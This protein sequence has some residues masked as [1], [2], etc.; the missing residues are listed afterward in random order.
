MPKGPLGARNQISVGDTGGQVK[1]LNR[2]S[3]LDFYL[4]NY[5][6]GEGRTEH[7]VACRIR[8]TKQFFFPFSSGAEGS[9]KKVAGW[10]QDLMDAQAGSAEVP[11]PEDPVKVPV[12]S[13]MGD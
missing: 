9:M 2:F 7:R 3:P 13:P 10:L 5:T 1:T 11:I 6:D 8:G 4:A 12:G